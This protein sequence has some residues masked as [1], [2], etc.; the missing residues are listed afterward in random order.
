MT[1]ISCESG[2]LPLECR[3]QEVDADPAQLVGPL[4][5]RG[6]PRVGDAC[7][8]DVVEPDDSD[9]VGDLHAGG[10][11]FVHEEESGLVV[12]AHDDIGTT[13]ADLRGHDLKASGIHVVGSMHHRLGPA[14]IGQRRHQRVAAN[15]LVGARRAADVGHRAVAALDQVVDH[16][17]HPVAIVRDAGNP[18]ADRDRHRA[19]AR[20]RSR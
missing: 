2:S 10:A 17:A 20:G 9:I 18:A 15:H 13:S 14:T 7:E 1:G 6:E 12:V 3:Q 4:R 16:L 5:H 11:Q 8:R 19:T